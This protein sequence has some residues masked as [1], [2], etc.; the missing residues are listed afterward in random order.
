VIH[1]HG[2]KPHTLSQ[3]LPILHTGMGDSWCPTSINNVEI[4][5]P[6]V[7]IKI[8]IKTRIN[9]KWVYFLFVIVIGSQW[10]RKEIIVS[11]RGLPKEHHLEHASRPNNPSPDRG[12]LCI[13]N[14]YGFIGAKAEV[15]ANHFLSNILTYL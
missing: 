2:T 9:Q 11:N 15:S 7:Q 13:I 1:A 8:L 6:L 10:K 14:P 4:L 12:K 3:Y 5:V